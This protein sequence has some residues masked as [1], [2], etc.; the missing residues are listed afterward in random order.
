MEEWSIKAI[1][2]MRLA[3]LVKIG[4]SLDLWVKLDYMVNT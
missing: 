4:T 1:L 3:C 2:I